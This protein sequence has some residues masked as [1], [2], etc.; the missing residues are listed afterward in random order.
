MLKIQDYPIILQNN[1]FPSAKVCQARST[2]SKQ[3][4]ILNDKTWP[5]CKQS[6]LQEC[7]NRHCDNIITQ[8]IESGWGCKN[9]I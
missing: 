8:Q 5:E 6:A 2:Y 7:E 4:C 1:I 3:F 9:S